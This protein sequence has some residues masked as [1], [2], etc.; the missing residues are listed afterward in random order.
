MQIWTTMCRPVEYDGKRGLG[1]FI[2][3]GSDEREVGRVA[4]L[5]EHAS[6]K[7]QSEAFQDQ[8]DKVLQRADQSADI[9]NETMSEVERLQQN[10]EAERATA[11]AERLMKEEKAL[12]E[13]D[14]KLKDAIGSSPRPSTW[15]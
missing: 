13:L 8:L 7:Y 12:A 6:K 2:T 14:S 9:V 10:A 1:V 5:R 3:D 11:E 15:T 4:Y